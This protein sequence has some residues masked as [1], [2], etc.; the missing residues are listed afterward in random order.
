ME[1]A[2]ADIGP[3]MA[4]GRAL[5]VLDA[6]GGKC[7]V[8]KELAAAIEGPAACTPERCFVSSVPV[9]PRKPPAEPA[10]P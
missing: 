8:V 10:K 9:P 6:S 7:A 1:R 4:D 3:E 5:L 2:V